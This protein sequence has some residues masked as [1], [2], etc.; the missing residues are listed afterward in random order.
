MTMTTLAHKFQL[1]EQLEQDVKLLNRSIWENRVNGSV[2]E[3][4]L[5]QF[6][7]AD[8]L[9]ED[10]QMHALFLLSHFLYFGQAEIRGLLTSLYRDIFRAPLL[11]EIR[12]ANGDTVDYT[13]V[14]EEYQRRLLATRFLAVG[15]PSESGMHLLYYFRQE[16][17]LP[18]TLFIN[19]HEIFDR[20]IHDSQVRTALHDESIGRY[21]FID[22]L[23]GSG[24][25]AVRYSRDVLGPLKALA[26]TVRASY[27][28]VFATSNGLDKVRRCTNFDAVET[29]FELD[30]SF[31]TLDEHSRIFRASD[32]GLNRVAVRETCHKY[33]RLLWPQEPLGYRNGQMLLGFSHNTPD[34]TLPIFWGGAEEAEISWIPAFRRYDKVYGP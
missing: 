22:D 9:N 28:V 34:N 17:A 16:N 4:W 24:T 23:C 27:F 1:R 2:R 7:A 19:T 29:V 6:E 33:G 21:V 14:S 5:A 25:Q 20:T 18:K 8:H 3:Q 12:R 31:R 15:N 26:P 11:Q 30:D 10:E 13:L 32:V